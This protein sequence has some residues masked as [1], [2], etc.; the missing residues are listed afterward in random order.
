MAETFERIY[1]PDGEW[2]ALFRRSAG[3]VETLLLKDHAQANR[4]LTI[5]RWK[6]AED[7]R[8]FRSRFG[9]EYDALDQRCERLTIQEQSL[10]AY[11]GSVA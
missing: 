7:Y 8:R 4:Y 11:E 10:G 1:G 2:A 6:S 5:D 3:Y 9:P